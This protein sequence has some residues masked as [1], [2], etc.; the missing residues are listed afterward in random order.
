MVSDVFQGNEIFIFPLSGVSFTDSN[1]MYLLSIYT[2]IFL[3]SSLSSEQML[4]V[5]SSLKDKCTAKRKASYGL[6]SGT[7]LSSPDPKV[8]VS[9]CHRQVFQVN[10]HGT[11]EGTFLIG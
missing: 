8:L 1:Y 10:I 4:G 5:I 9:Y 7:V 3:E 11:G 2:F 6:V